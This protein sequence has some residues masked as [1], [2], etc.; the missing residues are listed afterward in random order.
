MN[1]P[2]L[3]LIPTP[4][5]QQGVLSAEIACIVSTIT[6]YIAET[7]KNARAFLKPYPLPCPIQDISIKELNEHTQ[8]QQIQPLLAPLYEGRSLGLISDAGCPGIADPGAPLILLAHQAGFL[9]KPL[10]GPCSIT[11]ALM[12]S[13]LDGQR[14][15]FLGYLPQQENERIEKIRQ[16]EK[17]SRQQQSTILFI[18]TPYRN[19]KMIETVL[20]T[21]HP[22][23]YLSVATDLTL[24]TEQITTM[25]IDNWR[26]TKTPSRNK[27]PSVFLIRASL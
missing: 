12:A 5:G 27:R 25:T 4:L 19:D 15:Q 8:A 10:I 21:C 20:K 18:E 2:T 26:K 24:D 7:A 6:D 16:I 17:L 3:Y 22:A 9:V 23:T 13:G 11:L 14:H 1:H